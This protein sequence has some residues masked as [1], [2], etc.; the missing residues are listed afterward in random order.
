MNHANRIIL[1]NPIFQAFRKQ[2]ALP[3]IHPLNKALHPIPPQIAQE[4]YR[5]NHTDRRVFTQPGSEADSR[6]RETSSSHQMPGISRNLTRLAYSNADES[7]RCEI[8]LINKG[9]DEPHWIVGADIIV[10]SL[11][12]QQK[13][14]TFESKKGR[15]RPQGNPIDATFHTVWLISAQA[16]AVPPASQSYSFFR[17]DSAAAGAPTS[18]GVA[19]DQNCAENLRAST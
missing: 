17:N 7:R 16:I 6:E 12:Q 1:A 8:Q 2:C 15:R 11:R 10:H 3:A 5:K 4:S 13:L 18:K 14:R 9:V 19:S